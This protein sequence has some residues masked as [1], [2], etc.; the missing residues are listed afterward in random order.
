VT[1]PEGP[2]PGDYFAVF[3]IVILVVILLVTLIA[4]ALS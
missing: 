3:G 4:W 1:Y 2:G